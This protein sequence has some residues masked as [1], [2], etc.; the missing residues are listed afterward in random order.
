MILGMAVKQV[1][2]DWQR[3]YAI[4]P[5]LM[6]TFVET[7]RFAG[8]CYR[9]ANWVHVGKTKGRGKLGAAGIQSVPIKDILLY[10]MDKDYKKILTAERA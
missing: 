10:P 5:V 2:Q 1:P 3:R 4:K 9:A 7:D 6:E 8:T